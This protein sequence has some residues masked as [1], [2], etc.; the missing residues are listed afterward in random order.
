MT[1]KGWYDKLGGNN[2][3]MRKETAGR[4]RRGEKYDSLDWRR[5]VKRND[6]SFHDEKGRVRDIVTSLQ[7][8]LKCFIVSEVD[9]WSSFRPSVYFSFWN[10][11]FFF[12]V[13]VVIVVLTR[14]ASV[15]S[16]HPLLDRAS[17]TRPILNCSFFFPAFLFLFL[18]LP[19]S[20]SFVTFFF[21]LLDT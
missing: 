8:L 1:V 4:M 13:F 15:L 19:L 5:E 21:P 6:V 16:L 17:L 11:F 7:L 20:A 10:L 18:Y 3:Q 12:L 2:M 14:L 9:F